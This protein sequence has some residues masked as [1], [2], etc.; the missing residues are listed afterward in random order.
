MQNGLARLGLSF[1]LPGC[2]GDDLGA[3]DGSAVGRTRGQLQPA[4]EKIGLQVNG[5]P[6]LLGGAPIGVQQKLMR[7]TQGRHSVLGE[8]ARW[9][10]PQAYGVWFFPS[11]SSLLSAAAASRFALVGPLDG[12]D[13]LF[14]TCQVTGS[15]PPLRWLRKPS[16][17][18][19]SEPKSRRRR[20]VL[21]LPPRH[22]N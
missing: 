2:K 18:C 10:R 19:Q 16:S 17:M 5:Q 6:V 20:V 14:P 3:S 13:S 15:L 9:I 8:S 22:R 21:A 4:G 1:S 11:R 7:H 12:H